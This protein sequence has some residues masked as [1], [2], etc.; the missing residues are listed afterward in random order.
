MCGV[1][2]YYRTGLYRT[3]VTNCALTE[4]D[5][6]V[7]DERPGYETETIIKQTT[8]QKTLFSPF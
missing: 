8:N 6:Q 4:M 1:N 2:V 3:V 5:M 7:M